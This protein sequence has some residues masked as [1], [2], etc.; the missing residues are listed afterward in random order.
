MKS[1]ILIGIIGSRYGWCPPHYNVNG[2]TELKTWLSE[3]DE[4]LSVT[5]LEIRCFQDIN[6]NRKN[7]FFF[8]RNPSFLR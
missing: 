6:E 4:G 1:D 8:S 5:E 7:A 3:Q 2:K